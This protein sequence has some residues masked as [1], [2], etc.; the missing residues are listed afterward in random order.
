M[1]QRGKHSSSKHTII[2]R[3]AAGTGAL[4]VVLSA[5]ALLLAATASANFETVKVFAGSTAAPEEPTPGNPVWPEEV[6]LGGLGGMAVNRTG[7]GGVAPGTLYT[8]GSSGGDGQR[9]AR[10]SPDGE[11]ELAWSGIERRCGPK[12]VEPTEETCSPKPTGAGGAVD[13][14]VDQGT[15]NVFVLHAGGVG[16]NSVFEYSPDGSKLLAEFALRAPFGSNVTETPSELHSSG[17]SGLAVDD[18]GKVYV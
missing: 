2:R 14:D 13:I 18:T 12:A 17:P 6:Q 7:A 9:A 15:G 4:V 3:L 8:I 16:K 5:L 10:Y 11:F 1:R